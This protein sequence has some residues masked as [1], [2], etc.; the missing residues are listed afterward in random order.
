MTIQILH[1]RIERLPE[2]IVRTKLSR[3]TIYNLINAGKFPPK[4]KLGARSIGFLEA[5]I[6][7]WILS[8][9]AAATPIKGE[10]L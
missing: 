9:C 3:S 5:D 1:P 7:D 4:I 8:K 2:V 10:V 6:S